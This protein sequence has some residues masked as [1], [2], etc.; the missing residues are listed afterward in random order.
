MNNCNTNCIEKPLRLGF[1]KL[2]KCVARYSWW[3]FGI[4]L[5]ISAVL[6]SGFR[7]FKKVEGNDIEKQFT[8]ISGDAKLERTFVRQHFPVNFTDFSLDRLFTEGAFVSFIAVTKESNILTKKAFEEIL[9]L[10]K[11]VKNLKVTYENTEY[12][13]T[14]LCAKFAGSCYANPVLT[15]INYDANLVENITFE[16][17]RHN[18]SFIGSVVGGVELDGNKIKNA[19]AVRISYYLREDDVKLEKPT[20][21]WIQMFLDEISKSSNLK[22]IE[23]SY[24]SSISRQDEFEG[25]AKIIIPLFSVTY[26]LTITFSIV[27]CMRLDCVRNKVWVACLGVLSTGLAV[28][29]GFGLLVYCKV[30][31]AI[32]TANAP[33]LILGIGVD[34]VFIMLASWEKTNVNDSVEERASGAYSDAATSITITTLTDILAFYIGI[35]TPFPSVQSFC[36]YTGTTVLLSFIYNITFFGAIL[37]LNGKREAANR[38][39]LTLRK[40]EREHLPGESKCYRM[41]CVGGAYNEKTGAEIEH[42]VSLFM[43]N[44]YG[45]FLTNRWT[46]GVVV[47]LYLGYLAASFYGC[48]NLKE[49][50]DIRNLASDYSYVIKFY[51]DVSKYFSKYGPRVMVTVIQPVSYWDSNIQK[52]IERCMHAFE[53]LSYVDGDYSESWLRIYPGI[54]EQLSNVSIS[55]KHGFMKMLDT[56]LNVVHIY[57]QDIAIS[58]DKKNIEASRF[59]IQT[60]YIN[61]SIAEK[62]MLIELRDLA[63]DCSVPLHVF[64]PAFIYFDQYLVIISTTIQNIG[65]AAGAMLLIAL[66]LIP[67]PICS[68][69]VTF[70]IASV[71]VGVAGFMTLWGVNLDS[72][73]MINL[74][75]CIGF[76]VDFTAHISYAFV[77]SEKETANERSIDSLYRLG[78][79]IIQ[80]ALSTIMGVITLSSAASYIFRTFFKIMFLVITFGAVHGIVL[81]PVFMTFF[82]RKAAEKQAID[83]NQ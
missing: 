32:N 56:F 22:W 25:N 78:Y 29:T 33:F 59:F 83:P 67:N 40:V 62:N 9:V 4:P 24:F 30:S 71:L 21:M 34:N 74:V 3:F 68:I 19:Q 49:G 37:V 57:K 52:E 58:V 54:A 70:A 16:Y 17:P 76:S 8:P 48:F 60:I 43:K 12:D 20:E 18:K 42:P 5:V 64:H 26:F 82:R 11:M 47:V 63:K 46:K 38:H 23:I 61:D 73:S 27:S 41:C 75:I 1:A 2:G 31:F 79:P 69:W 15:I 50:I 44:R 77:S 14:I 80:G 39:W 13:F 45:P 51:D 6:G 66:L 28:L 7:N 55:N 36:V 81:M 65:V 10:D 35:M 53:N 72:I